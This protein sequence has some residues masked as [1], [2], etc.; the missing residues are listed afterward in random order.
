MDEIL[1]GIF[2]WVSYHE[3]I[4]EDVH[5]YYVSSTRPAVLF[6]PRVPEEGVEWFEY[7][8]QPKH[9]YLTNRHHYRHSD[10]FVRAFGATVWC[11]EEGLY[12]F[13]REHPVSGFASGADLP[14][15]VRAVEVGVLCPE[16]TA[17]YLPRSGGILVIGDSIIRDNGSLSFVPDPLLGDEPEAV[18]RGLSEVYREHLSLDFDHL[19]LAHGAPWIRGAK[20]AL[21][22]FLDSVDASLSPPTRRPPSGRRPARPGT[23]RS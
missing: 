14:G 22:R 15:G 9:I 16:E 19:L 20:A 11:H 2:H 6:D 4:G 12:W 10:R 7:R 18:K 21:R 23:S 1:P 17:Y 5:S 13:E 3:G 8:P